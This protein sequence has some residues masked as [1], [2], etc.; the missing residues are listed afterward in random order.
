[1][2]CWSLED[3]GNNYQQSRITADCLI[4]LLEKLVSRTKVIPE[5]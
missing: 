5:I 2:E 1:M 4:P 3:E